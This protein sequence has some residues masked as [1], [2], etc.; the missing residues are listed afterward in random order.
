MY[1]IDLN[2]ALISPSGDKIRVAPDPNKQQDKDKPPEYLTMG[3]VLAQQLAQSS[4]KGVT[5]VKYWGWVLELSAKRPLQL[6]KAD[7]DTLKDF[8]DNAEITVLAKAQLME[9]LSDCQS[10]EQPDSK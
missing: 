6:D 4:A 9:A 2:K 8:V 7:F 10:T 1:V 5:A 3:S